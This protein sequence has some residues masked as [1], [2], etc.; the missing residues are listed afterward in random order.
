MR[1][2]SVS[3]SAATQTSVS[4]SKGASGG[5]FVRLGTETGRRTA[6]ALEARRNRKMWHRT[7]AGE[8]H[9]EGVPAYR[10]GIRMA[11]EEGRP[12]PFPERTVRRWLAPEKVGHD[13]VAS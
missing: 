3:L 11:K 4:G 13:G 2:A 1:S 9:A 8:L 6:K 5:V 10:I 12:Q 7:R